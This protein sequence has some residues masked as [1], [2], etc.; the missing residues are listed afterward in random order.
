MRSPATVRHPLIPRV[1][2]TP[3]HRAAFACMRVSVCH[4]RCV[5]FA[6]VQVA[7][8]NRLPPPIGAG[9]TS[10]YI[11][12]SSNA[13]LRPG[14]S[15]ITQIIDLQTPFATNDRQTGQTGRLYR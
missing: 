3:A 9:S 2:D 15:L 5:F 12:T 14:N 13:R 4:G 11:Y 7:Y 8:N 6:E 10:L 1:Q